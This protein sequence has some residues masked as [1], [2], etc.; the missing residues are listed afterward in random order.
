MINICTFS[1]LLEVYPNRLT[2]FYI[3]NDLLKVKEKFESEELCA[4][5]IHVERNFYLIHDILVS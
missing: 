3:K 1:F 2:D 4:L 5:H